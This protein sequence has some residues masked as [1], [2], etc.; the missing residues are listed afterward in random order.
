VTIRISHSSRKENRRMYQL[1][2]SGLV[3]LISQ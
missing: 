1:G 3:A 2:L